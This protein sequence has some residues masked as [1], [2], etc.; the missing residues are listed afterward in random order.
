VAEIVDA[1]IHGR[2]EDV[3]GL[4]T[5]YAETLGISQCFQGFEQE[6]ALN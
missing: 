2:M 4:F 3:R 5:E 1:Q 6:L